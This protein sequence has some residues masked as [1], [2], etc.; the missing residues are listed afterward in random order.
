MT[1]KETT[2]EADTLLWDVEEVCRQLSVGR[3]T[4]LKLTYA[5]ELP[6]VTLAYRRLWSARLVREW[7]DA[8]PVAENRPRKAGRPKFWEVPNKEAE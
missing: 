6:S 2:N 3:Q 8:L 4:V 5:G 1:G 7:V